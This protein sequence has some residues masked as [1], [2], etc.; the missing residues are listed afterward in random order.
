MRSLRF[1]NQSN[2]KIKR[3]FSKIFLWAI[4]S[5]S[6][7]L[8]IF[9]TLQSMGVTTTISSLETESSSILLENRKLQRELVMKTS[10]KDLEAKAS[11]L[12]YV[13]QSTPLY[14]KIDEVFAQALR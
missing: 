12:G 10:L 6:M 11:K 7:L 13:T 8:K 3:S 1:K 9:F 4:F 2:S 5:V 14:I